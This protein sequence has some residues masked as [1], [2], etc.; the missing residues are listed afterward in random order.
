MRDLIV[1]RNITLEG[2]IE[3]TDGWFDPA[4]GEDG[5]SDV[6]TVLRK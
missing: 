1:T 3:A 4:G 2:V 6:E 5:V